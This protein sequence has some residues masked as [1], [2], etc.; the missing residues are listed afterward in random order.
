MR[1]QV[2][3]TGANRVSRT[4]TFAYD[5]LYQLTSEMDSSRNGGNPTLYTYDAMGNR[6]SK[7]DN[8]VTTAYT[9]DG[10]NRVTAATTGQEQVTYAY[11]AN[12]NTASKTAGGVTTTYAY[13]AAGRQTGYSY[14]DGVTPTVS[15]T[16]NYLDQT[17]VIT[18]AAGTRN[19]TYNVNYRLAN[20]TNPV[21]VNGMMNYTYD[22][23]GRRTGMNLTDGTIRAQA[24]YTYDTAGRVATVGDGGD[25]L[26]YTYAPGTDRVA[27]T[28][29]TT[30]TGNNTAYTYDNYKRL[31]NIAVN[32]TPIYGYTLNDKD[33]RTAATLENGDNWAYTYDTLGQLTGALKKDSQDNTLNNMSYAFDLIGNRT[34]ATEDAANWTYASNLLNQYTQVNALLPTYDA[35]GNMLTWNGWTYTW[36]GENRLVCAESDDTKVEMSYDYMGRRFEKKVYT[37]GLLNLYTWTLQKHR[38]FAYDGYKLI[39]EFD[40][41]NSNALLAN[42]LWQP[43]GLD[44]P[45]RATIDGDACYFIADGNKNIIALKD[46]TGVTT[47]DYTYAPFGAVTTSGATDNPFRFSSEYHDVETGFVYYN[48]RYYN[49][50]LGRWTKRDP[51]EEKGGMNLYGFVKDNPI[52]GYDLHGLYTP[53]IIIGNAGRPDRELDIWYCERAIDTTGLDEGDTRAVSVLNLQHVYFHFGINPWSKENKDGVGFSGGHAGD[54]PTKEKAFKPTR[55][56]QC[57]VETRGNAKLKHG[58]G[59]EKPCCKATDEEIRDCIKKYPARKDYS[60]FPTYVCY[61]WAK[62]AQEKCCMTCNGKSKTGSDFK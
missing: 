36:N 21:I 56:Q 60:K 1:T 59:K 54:L 31:T 12:G 37:K 33:Q 10:L 45:L 17:T 15:L 43:V 57:S 52:N 49:P 20:E 27:S 53:G 38:K 23:Y 29:W 48:Y 28:A 25:T 51:I 58:I 30:A 46:A 35:D 9:V 19:F 14:S 61:T 18:D 50:A 4:L 24:G 42:Y 44:V 13:D 22:A 5:N 40:A 16:L 26:T 2:A 6:L 39:A 7:T 62:E 8:G 32:N 11:D 55:C 47:D 3:E 34:A 41:M